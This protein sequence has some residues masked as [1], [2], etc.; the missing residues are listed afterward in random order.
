MARPRNFT[1]LATRDHTGEVPT[2]LTRQNVYVIPD[3]L[4]PPLE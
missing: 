2:A 4:N 1:K 3:A